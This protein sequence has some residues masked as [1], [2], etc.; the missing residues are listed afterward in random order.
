MADFVYI[1]IYGISA[2]SYSNMRSFCEKQSLVKHCHKRMPDF[3]LTT[4][5]R[6]HFVFP[7][8]K[9]KFKFFIF[10]FFQISLTGKWNVTGYIVVQLI[11]SFCLKMV[12]SLYIC[13]FHRWREILFSCGGFVIKGDEKHCLKMSENLSG[14]QSWKLFESFRGNLSVSANYQWT[15]G[16]YHRMT[17]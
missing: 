12:R 11:W 3:G 7:F 6:C 1:L 2:V 5:T 14:L 16:K 4:G 15:M 13:V 17:F 10:Y 8:K 9:T